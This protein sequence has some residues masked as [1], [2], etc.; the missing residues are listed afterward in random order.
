MDVNALAQ[1][2][3]IVLVAVAWKLA[4]AIVLWLVGRWL[5][6]FALAL[7]GRALAR[8]SFDVTLTRYLQTTLNIL[9]NV[10]S[11]SRSSAF[12]ASKP[13]RSRR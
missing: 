6:S 4:G 9:L 11:S 13:P 3:S 12:S 1:S 5:I 8:E 7:L 10:A 2:A